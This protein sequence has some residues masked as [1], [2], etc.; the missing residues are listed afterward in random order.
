MKELKA[1]SRCLKLIREKEAERT[2]DMISKA[3][4]Q[5]FAQLDKLFI[6]KF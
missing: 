2:K 1:A 5:L 4:D 3:K 6:S